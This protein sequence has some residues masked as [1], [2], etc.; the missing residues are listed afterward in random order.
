VGKGIPET[1]SEHEQDTARRAYEKEMVERTKRTAKISKAEIEAALRDSET[2]GSGTRPAVDDSQLRQHASEA[3]DRDIRA[4]MEELS[5]PIPVAAPAARI[6]GVAPT[7]HGDEPAFDPHSRPTIDAFRPPPEIVALIEKKQA[8][9]AEQQL[10]GGGPPPPS[11]GRLPTAKMPAYKP[12]AAGE[13]T[14]TKSVAKKSRSREILIPKWFITLCVV[15][16]IML[17][18][19]AGSVG[20]YLSHRLNRELPRPNPP[21]R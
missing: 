7:P 14:T 3:L 17:I 9:Q 20:F 19:A 5:P 8:E 10:D 12:V 16:V 13:T 1:F 11:E 21:S 18:A 4:R 15:T 6:S 2:G